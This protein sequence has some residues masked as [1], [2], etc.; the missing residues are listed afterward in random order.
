[1]MGYTITT[2]PTFLNNQNGITTEVSDKFQRYHQLALEGKKSS[3]KKILDVID[4]YPKIPQF[5]NYLSVLYGQLNETQKMYDVNKWI[6][7]EHPDYLFGKLNLASEY[8]LK[9]EYDKIPYILGEQMELKALYPDRDT[10]HINEVFSF[11]KCAVLY[12]SAIGD[13]EQAEIRYDIM[14]ELG[15][16]ATETEIAKRNLTAAYLQAVEKRFE[17]EE[18]RKIKVKTKPQEISNDS[19]APKFYHKEIEWLYCNGLHIEEEKLN[20]ILS[21]PKDT[22]IQDLELV[23]QDSINR[24]GYFLK[25]TE[26]NEWNE[27]QTYFVI[28]SLF[29]LGE[30]QARESTIAIFKV[31][32]QSHDYLEFY[33]GDFLTDSIWEVVYKIAAD[34]LEV[35]KQFIFKSGM[36]TY[37]RAVFT[38]MVSQIVYHHPERRNEAINWYK[39]VI[40]FFLNSSFEDNV[41][42]SDLIALM[43]CSIIEIEGKELLPEI[44]KLYDRGLV[45]III[46]GDWKEVSE[47]LTPNDKHKYNRKREIL[48]IAER[49]K[50]VTSTWAGDDEE[51][52]NWN[53]NFEDYFESPNRP[54][55]ANPKI[56]RNQPCPCGSG[57]KYKKCCLNI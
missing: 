6:I 37:V 11:L 10:F 41:I 47:A 1:M 26:E 22:L 12:F 9:K 29:L 48:P 5:K 24:Y 28:H 4:K 31:L 30:L 14:Y 54:V 46:V 18:K 42:D 8:Y 40:L 17:E 27:E 50:E 32:S 56:G 53:Y 34:N 36:N 51:Q 33:L 57:K 13:I 21:L 23:L 44:K 25:L 35:C 52:S 43:I 19:K 16:D 38:D 39:D 45:S 7:A 20:T 49:Y 55:D 2:D 15:P 3:I